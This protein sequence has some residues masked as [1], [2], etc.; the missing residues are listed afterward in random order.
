MDTDL[1]RLMHFV[2]SPEYVAIE[3]EKDL[4]FTL[5]KKVNE[6]TKEELKQIQAEKEK[7]F[8]ERE[9]EQKKELEI[10]KEHIDIFFRY[11][12]NILEPISHY[13]KLWMQIKARLN[14]DIKSIYFI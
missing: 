3:V 12:W 6:P 4:L 8:L 14:G 10:A 13:M 5:W 7:L 2:S 9:K 11:G 1:L